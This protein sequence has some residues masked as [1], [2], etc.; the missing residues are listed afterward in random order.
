MRKTMLADIAE[1]MDEYRAIQAEGGSGF[2]GWFGFDDI[3]RLFELSTDLLDILR[4]VWFQYSLDRRIRFHEGAGR[5]AGG[6][7][8]LEDV[9]HQLRL[10]GMIDQ[11][12]LEMDPGDKTLLSQGGGS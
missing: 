2:E 11:R 10:A 9:E 12:G 5:W 8:V 7:S 6:L 4:D 1:R 3:E